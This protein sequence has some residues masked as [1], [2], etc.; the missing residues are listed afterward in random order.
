MNFNGLR[1]YVNDYGS[2]AQHKA[3]TILFAEYLNKLAANGEKS[4][5]LAI[6][7]GIEK[8]PH[9]LMSLQANN[10]DLLNNEQTK[11]DP[12]I[13]ILKVEIPATNM[14]CPRFMS[15]TRGQITLEEYES[16]LFF[17]DVSGMNLKRIPRVHEVVQIKYEN[18]TTPQFDGYPTDKI[19]LDP[20]LGMYSGKNTKGYFE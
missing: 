11:T 14:L 13:T 19:M 1:G 4:K 10:Q 16:S 12:Q 9:F 7:R 17:L 6:V 18:I 20:Y 8:E 5:P 3:V 2:I 15:Y